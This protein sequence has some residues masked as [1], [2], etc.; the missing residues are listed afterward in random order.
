[1]N[2]SAEIRAAARKALELKLDAIKR[3]AW[4]TGFQV[5]ARIHD[6]M[7]AAKDAEPMLVSATDLIQTSA[8]SLIAVADAMGF[9][10]TVE[11]TIDPLDPRNPKVSVSYWT[12][13]N[14]DGNYDG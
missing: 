4:A 7:E 13:R 14:A 11:R 3:Q 1:V 9:N 8:D 6:P 5:E 12:K 2:D 10:V